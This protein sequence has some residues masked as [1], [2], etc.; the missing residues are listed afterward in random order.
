MPVMDGLEAARA[1]RASGNEVPIVALTADAMPSDA[2][3]AMAAGMD[4]HIAKPVRGH[5]LS[6]LLLRVGRMRSAS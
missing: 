3:L 5:V 1:I 2:R 6:K 4:D